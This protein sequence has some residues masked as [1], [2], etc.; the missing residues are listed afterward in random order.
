[1]AKRRKFLAGLGALASGSAAAVGT[2]AFTSASLENRTVSVG[3]ESDSNSQI[4]LVAGDVPD[5][6][7]NSNGELEL[8]LTGDEGEGVNANS[9]YT[10]GDPESPNSN[11]AFALVNNDESNYENIEF[12]YTLNN[13][14][15][16]ED[17]G[18]ESHIAFKLYRD[19][20]YSK[21]LDAP[22]PLEPVETE[23]KSMAQGI[24]F[25]SGETWPV[26]VEVDTDPH[27]A[28]KLNDGD[29]D[30]SGELTI[31]VSG[32]TQSSD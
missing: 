31:E 5:I 11:Y 6:S 18:S 19:G 23:S 2:G 4:G 22:R 13:S 9:Q 29:I 8:D 32:R 17:E 24:I 21:V 7:E 10:W 27:T 30:L 3:V 26:V 12:T 25:D 15:W 28:E 20:N 14:D 16:L 1:M